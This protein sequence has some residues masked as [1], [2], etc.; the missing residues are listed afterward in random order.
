[1]KKKAKH[2]IHTTSCRELLCSLTIAIALLATCSAYSQ[3]LPR[4]DY[5]NSELKQHQFDQQKWESITEGL[6][7]NNFDPAD[8]DEETDQHQGNQSSSNHSGSNSSTRRS[9]GSASPF[10]IGFFKVL[11]FIIAI[12]VIAIILIHLVGGGA[13]M[14]PKSKKI[15]M[16]DQTIDIED[17]EANI[18]ESDLDRHIRAAIEQKNYALAIRLYYLAIIKEL[19]LSKKIKWKRDKTNKDYL[20]EMRNTKLF[21]PYREVTRIFERAWYGQTEIQEP[22]FQKIKPQFVNLIEQAKR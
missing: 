17:I 14:R 2:S 20:R 11:A 1:M 15:P 12:G 4:D 8:G 9:M 10:W 21:Q 22:D 16:S 18:H 13:L 3:T 6:D 7:Y 19:S 5:Y